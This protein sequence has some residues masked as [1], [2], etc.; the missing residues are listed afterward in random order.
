MAAISALVLKPSLQT[1]QLSVVA[2]GAYL[3]IGH[4]KQA[5]AVSFANC[6][7]SH[8]AQLVP[9]TLLKVPSGHEEHSAKPSP[10]V[11]LPAAHRIHSVGHGGLVAFK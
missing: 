3:P 1:I 5:L 8:D 2:A 9:S 10:V 7:G 4:S 6:P 11:T